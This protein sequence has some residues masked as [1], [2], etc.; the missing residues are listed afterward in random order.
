M[1]N[2]LLTKYCNKGEIMKREMRAMT[3]EEFTKH[4]ENLYKGLDE[5]LN[6]QNLKVDY[7]VPVLRSGAVPAV[8]LANK[9]NIVKFAPFQVKHITYEDK[10]ETIEIIFNPLKA[11]NIEKESPIFLIVEGTHSSGKS[12]ELCIDEIL[13]HYPIA[14]I[15]YVCITKNYES[16]SFSDKVV[17]ENFACQK[18]ETLT[19][20]ECKKLGIE[21][22]DAIYPWETFEGEQNHPDDLEKNIFF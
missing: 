10:K 15:L 13:K 12:V 18:S 2:K 1:S 22:L 3:H 7:I 8:Y 5:F 9:L 4:I 16:K 20:E 21:H 11:L 14:K 17:Y 19:E 6:K